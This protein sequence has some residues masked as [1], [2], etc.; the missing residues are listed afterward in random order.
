MKTLLYADDRAGQLLWNILTPVLIYS[1]EMLGE[2]ADDIVAIDQAMKWGFGWELGP[3]EL[4]DAIGLEKSIKKLEEKNG[5]VPDWVKEMLRAR[6]LLPFIKKKRV[7]DITTI[8]VNI[9]LIE[10][11][12]KVLNL[13]ENKAAKRSNQEK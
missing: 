11:N 2:I 5:K 9:I 10:E 13:A 7:N 12:P 6:L 1:A 3:F 4:W 8:R